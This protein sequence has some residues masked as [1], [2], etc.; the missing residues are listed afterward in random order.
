MH[1][2]AC[3]KPEAMMT[4]AGYSVCSTHGREIT[5]AIIVGKSAAHWF[6]GAAIEN[7]AAR[8]LL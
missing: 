4:I 7:Y 1:C 2:A 6:R 8:G 3:R 5:E